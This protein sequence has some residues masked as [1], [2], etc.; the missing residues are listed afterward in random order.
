MLAG[1]VENVKD[2]PPVADESVLGVL[3]A[4][5]VKSV[6]TPVVAPPLPLTVIVHVA[7]F[8]NRNGFA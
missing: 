6:D 1:M 3:V 7:V 5:T 4:A 8:P 2:A